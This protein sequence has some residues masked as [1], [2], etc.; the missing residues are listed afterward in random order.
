[1]AIIELTVASEPHGTK[2]GD[3]STAIEAPKSSVHAL[4][5]GLIAIG[6]LREQDGR[7]FTGPAVFGL[8]GSGQP[9][10]PATYRHA[11]EELTAKWEETT[12]IATLVGDSIVYVDMVE[13]PRLIRAAPPLHTRF[14]LWPRSSGKVFLAFMDNRRR[15]AILRRSLPD[16]AER[17]QAKEAL[18]GIRKLSL[19]ANLG[20]T[21][22]DQSGIASPIVNANAPVT[23]ALAMAGPSSRMD[24]HIDEIS[25]SLKTAAAALSTST[26]S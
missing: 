10:L 25:E 19:S 1:M 15:D 2:L 14:P 13:S 11:L 6:Y 12:F 22:P 4:T 18:V 20:E 21:E 24:P 9:S 26:T 17:D 8:L 3:L 16:A 7:Y 23:M 5:K